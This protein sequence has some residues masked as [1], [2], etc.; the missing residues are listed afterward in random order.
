MLSSEKLTCKGTLRQVAICLR[1]LPLLSFCFR[2]SSNFVGSEFG[3]IQ[4]VG[5]LQTMVTNRTQHPP[6]SPSHTLS[7]YAVL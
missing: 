1:P 2:L 4:S 5:L 6:P 7:V 3:Q